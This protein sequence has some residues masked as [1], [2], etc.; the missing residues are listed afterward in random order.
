MAERFEQNKVSNSSPR[1]PTFDHQ[2]ETEQI[3]AHRN[4]DEK[5]HEVVSSE[6]RYDFSPKP[7]PS[8]LRSLAKN[9]LN[10]AQQNAQQ[11]SMDVV[12]QR[13]LHELPVLERVRK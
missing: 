6:Q 4:A 8:N 5:I 2:K 13:Q 9:K 12:A 3:L 11:K 10:N 7:Q 1:S